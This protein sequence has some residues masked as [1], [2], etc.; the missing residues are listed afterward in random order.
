MAE[1][2]ISKPSRTLAEYRL[3]T[4]HTT[5]A[6]TPDKVS[7]RTRFVKEGSKDGFDYLNIPVV[8]AAMQAVSGPEL[9]VEL[10][11]LGSLAFIYCS[12]SIEAEAEM[13]SKIKRHKAG[14]VEPMTL[15]PETGI[16]RTHIRRPNG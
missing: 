13:V 1:R 14:F 2:I 10:A 7:L 6:C 15:K 4:G 9:A 12:Q 11:R 3:L 16:S 8:G 5:R